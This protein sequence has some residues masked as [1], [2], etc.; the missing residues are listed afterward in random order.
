KMAGRLFGEGFHQRLK[1]RVGGGARYPGPE[2]DHRPVSSAGVIGELEGKINVT[3]APGKAR[4]RYAYDG[5]VLVYQLQ[6]AAD[7]SG[8]AVV[9]PLP[10]LV[11]Q[12]HH[13]L[14][15]L[16]LR[17]VGGNKSPSQQGGH[18]KVVE[19]VRGEVHPGDVLRKFAASGAQAPLVHCSPT[20]DRLGLSELLKLGPGERH[21][22][23]VAVP[24][25]GLVHQM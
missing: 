15:I 5:V 16:A 18:A 12:N 8:V 23:P 25:L 7:H 21:E 2:L 10:E 1:L 24:G 22:V 3:I 9:V 6:G 19:S 17:R 13:W 14:R 11:A 20:F 4:R